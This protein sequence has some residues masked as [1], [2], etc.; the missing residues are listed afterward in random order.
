MPFTKEELG[1]VRNLLE[2]FS[3]AGTKQ[4]YKYNGTI[5]DSSEFQNSKFK[6]LEE[7]NK[8]LLFR[9]WQ[10][11]PAVLL[12]KM[13]AVDSNLKGKIKIISHTRNVEDIVGGLHE[14]LRKIS[15][16][17]VIPGDEYDY[18]ADYEKLIHFALNLMDQTEE[19][20]ENQIRTML[21][22]APIQG[23]QNIENVKKY[24]E[25]VRP[26]V[27]DIRETVMLANMQREVNKY[28]TNPN[29]R[30]AF[31]FGSYHNFW[32]YRD[33]GYD[34]QLVIPES[35]KE[36]SSSSDENDFKLGGLRKELKKLDRKARK[37]IGRDL[38]EEM[39]RILTELSMRN[40]NVVFRTKKYT[41]ENL[42]K[43]RLELLKSEVS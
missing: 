23:F 35:M 3:P 25:R 40:L 37:S 4:E 14:E 34:F 39:D 41:K 42:K 24:V 12:E 11:D 28:G 38:Q 9:A 29:Y 1:R 13:V 16:E 17:Y 21:K 18:E 8:E 19:N 33:I 20:E 6:S 36:S 31:T 2:S 5:Y 22:K 27:L 10:L 7:R 26:L 43:I 15:Q 30:F 32:Q